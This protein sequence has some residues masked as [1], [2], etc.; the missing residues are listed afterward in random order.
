MKKTIS[1]L[2]VFVLLLSF[3]SCNKRV[4]DDTATLNKE[5][6]KAPIEQEV[7][8]KVPEKSDKL[9]EDNL[10]SVPFPQE[11][12]KPTLPETDNKEQAA[13]VP[14][15]YPELQQLNKELRNNLWANDKFPTDVY[16]AEYLPLKLGYVTKE[17]NDYGNFF[18]RTKKEFVTKEPIT[19]QMIE[20]SKEYPYDEMGTFYLSSLLKIN[21]PDDFVPKCNMPRNDREAF[22]LCQPEKYNSN[23]EYFES[24]LADDT[25]VVKGHFEAGYG[26]AYVE[27][28]L[29]SYE[30]TSF[31]YIIDPYTVHNFV[32]EKVY[33]ENC[34][35]KEGDIVEVGLGGTIMQNY[36][37][38]YCSINTGV[39]FTSYNGYTNFKDKSLEQR[40]FV[41]S[42][43]PASVGNRP[44][45]L[46]IDYLCQNVYDTET[47]YDFDAFALTITA[48]EILEKY[49]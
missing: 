26:T 37:G 5:E 35:Y 45:V 21:P 41:L 10:V 44:D 40:T 14:L 29:D 39:G 42:L 4:D 24:W 30:K 25:F 36:D 43:Q 28:A 31:N 15:R 7:S 49:N 38:F 12:N 8:E 13:D 22:Y 1:I 18:Y 34:G 2:L 48:K 27:Y 17:Y 46:T 47:V 33:T 32:I 11:E 6:S 19:E 16:V 20:A 23:I 3:S 9:S